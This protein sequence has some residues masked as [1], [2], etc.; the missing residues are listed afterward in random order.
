M[1]VCRA[2]SRRGRLHVHA[3]IGCPWI[4]PHLRAARI[5]DAWILRAASS[6]IAMITAVASA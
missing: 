5:G 4:V 1:R 6:R 2:D 3:G